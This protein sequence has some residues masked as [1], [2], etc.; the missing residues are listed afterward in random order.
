MHYILRLDVFKH[1]FFFFDLGFLFFDLFIYTILYPALYYYYFLP[2]FF[3]WSIDYLSLHII[4]FV[5]RFSFFVFDFLLSCVDI[6]GFFSCCH[7]EEIFIYF[8]DHTYN[9]NKK[10]F[11]TQSSFRF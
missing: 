4:F 7:R 3:F 5:F 8:V 10:H 1:L 2:F 11:C 6:F 9:N